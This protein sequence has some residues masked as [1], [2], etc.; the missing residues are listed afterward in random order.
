MMELGDYNLVWLKASDRT[1][2]QVRNTEQ[3]FGCGLW[4]LRDILFWCCV[5]FFSQKWLVAMDVMTENLATDL[6]FLQKFSW[7]IGPFMAFQVAYQD[8][9]ITNVVFE[10]LHEQFLQSGWAVGKVLMDYLMFCPLDTICLFISPVILTMLLAA[11]LK[12]WCTELKGVFAKTGE[13][14]LFHFFQI[15]LYI[16]PPENV[17]CP[18]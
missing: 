5:V 13:A 18:H 8:S 9:L 6:V 14:L 11:T 15:L 17:L 4:I 3:R 7:T 1:W 2:V 12:I 16:C 10:N